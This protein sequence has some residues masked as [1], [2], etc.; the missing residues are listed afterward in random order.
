MGTSLSSEEFLHLFKVP[1][2]PKDYAVVFAVSKSVLVLS[3]ECGGLGLGVNVNEFNI[4]LGET[5]IV[6][7][8]CKQI[9]QRFTY[10]LFLTTCKAW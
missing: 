4:Y 3:R 1:V 5:N 9:S 2:K 7:D 10:N 6:T 8:K